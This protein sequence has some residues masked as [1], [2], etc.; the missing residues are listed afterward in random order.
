MLPH[1]RARAPGVIEVDVRQ[2]QLPDVRDRDP[3]PLQGR[4]QVLERRGRPG[5]DQRDVSRC[6]EDGG[7]DDL[8]AAKKVEVDLIKPGGECRHGMEAQANLTAQDC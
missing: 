2:Q 4:T 8:G 1:E 5:I 3:L 7:G 6:L